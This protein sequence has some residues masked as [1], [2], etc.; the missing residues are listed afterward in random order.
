MKIYSFPVSPY[1]VQPYSKSQGGDKSDRILKTRTIFKS[2]FLEMPDQCQP[3]IGRKTSLV[4]WI[5]VIFLG[6]FEG[7][8]L[9]Q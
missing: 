5:K 1:V 2:K 7:K 3:H 6:L 9:I 8:F 4:N